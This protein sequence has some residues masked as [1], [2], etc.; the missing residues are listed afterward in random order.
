MSRFRIILEVSFLAK[1]TLNGISFY[2]LQ[3]IQQFKGIRAFSREEERIH[4]K[5]CLKVWSCQVILAF[6]LC[7]LFCE[8]F[9]HC[10]SV[11]P[12]FPWKNCHINIGITDEI[13]LL[14]HFIPFLVSARTFPMVNYLVQAHLDRKQL[15]IVKKNTNQTTTTLSLQR[16]ERLFLFWIK[17]PFENHER[18]K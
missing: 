10:L 5:K 1:T 3:T 12:W 17:R 2:D 13:S 14:D 9:D 7:A 18:T 16:F 6:Y 11:R 4:G 15:N 8:L